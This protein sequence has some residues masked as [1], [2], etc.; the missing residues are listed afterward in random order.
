MFFRSPGELKVEHGL[1]QS[2]R[3]R[4]H[5]LQSSGRILIHLIIFFITRISG[6]V[7]TH[8]PLFQHTLCQKDFVSLG[9]HKP[10]IQLGFFIPRHFRIDKGIYSRTGL[11]HQTYIFCRVFGTQSVSRVFVTDFDTVIPITHRRYF[12]QHVSLLVMVHTEGI[13]WRAIIKLMTAC[14]A[15]PVPHGE[16]PSFGIGILFIGLRAVAQLVIGI[17]SQVQL[18]SFIGHNHFCPPIMIII[19]TRYELLGNHVINVIHA[20]ACPIGSQIGFY[21]I[22]NRILP[23]C[24]PQRQSRWSRTTECHHCK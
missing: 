3:S 5:V 2:R 24:C 16:T 12:P 18:L 9:S 19:A 17:I 7:G 22:R 23:L 15:F 14:I 13:V 6:L 1:F 11:I 8:Q 21:K 10:P 4:F 20:P